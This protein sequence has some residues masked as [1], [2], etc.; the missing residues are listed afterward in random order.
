M[1]LLPDIN[2]V[3]CQ[4]SICMIKKSYSDKEIA[5]NTNDTTTVISQQEAI[6]PLDISTTTTLVSKKKKIMNYWELNNCPIIEIGKKIE[7]DKVLTHTYGEMY[8]ELFENLCH[9][10]KNKGMKNKEK[11][12]SLNNKNS[13][14]LRMLEIGFGCGHHVQGVSSVLWKT[15]FTE[16]GPGVTL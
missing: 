6:S 13:G 7:E 5:N 8:C 11:Y 1:V 10:E 15:Y 4:K 3:R 14:K 9:K 2:A 16:H 12:H